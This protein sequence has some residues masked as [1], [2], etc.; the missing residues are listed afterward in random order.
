M[1]PRSQQNQVC[2]Y[3]QQGNCRFGDSCQFLH[4]GAGMGPAGRQGQPS[5]PFAAL[6]QPGGNGGATGFA[7]TAAAAGNPAAD[8]KAYLRSGGFPYTCLKGAPNQPLLMQDLLSPEELRWK[9]ME[10]AGGQLNQQAS[11]MVE[12]QARARVE[13]SFAQ[14]SQTA[15]APSSAA[16]AAGLSGPAPQ[17]PFAQL[18][19][20]P[21]PFGQPQSAPSPFSASPTPPQPSQPS[22]P[23]FTAPPQQ[24]TAGGIFGS[25]AGSGGVFGS[26]AAGM[27]R[28][29]GV[30]GGAG[31]SATSNLFGQGGGSGGSVFGGGAAAPAAPVG[32][33][34][35]QIMNPFA[36]AQSGPSPFGPPPVAA[37]AAAA[38]A[39]SAT[40]PTQGEATPEVVPISG[41]SQRIFASKDPFPA[42]HE[43]KG[44]IPE[45]MPPADV[46]TDV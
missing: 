13:S 29:G 23:V 46:C 12:Q 19:S 34:G 26:S 42:R 1:P 10:A 7:S 14:L 24:P 8:F 18:Q 41:E 27:G 43:G 20:A 28:G 2:R 4:P 36:A 39:S 16:S 9:S 11:Q 31:G 21:S 3:W 15:P 38:A 22:A 35:G 37:A 25:A 32:G 44:G 45:D 5:N 6:G 33:G 40:T 30:F 17:N